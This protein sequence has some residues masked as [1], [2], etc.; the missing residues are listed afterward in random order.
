MRV[1]NQKDKSEHY[2]QFPEEAYTAGTS[3]NLVFDTKILRL[4][5]S[6]MT[7]PATVFDYDLDTRAF[8]LLKE[9]EV[10]GGFNKEDYRSE[11][12]NAIVRDGVEVP[13][14]LVYKKGFKVDGKSPLLLYAYGFLRAQ[15]R[16]L[17]FIEP[18]F[19]VGSRICICHCTHS[20]WRRNGSRLV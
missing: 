3:V 6:S 20:R 11:R 7:T 12:L 14:S 16:S 8:T 17:L 4:V 5:Y 19:A 9:Q 13:I 15:F 18:S 2:I 10:L 1:F